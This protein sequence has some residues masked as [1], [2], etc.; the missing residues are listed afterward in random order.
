MIV[1]IFFW[2]AGRLL[3]MSAKAEIVMN[4]EIPISQNKREKV[5]GFKERGWTMNQSK[6]S[7]QAS[8]IE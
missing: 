5:T 4:V 8:S 2:R 7:F 3:P 6:G 1:E